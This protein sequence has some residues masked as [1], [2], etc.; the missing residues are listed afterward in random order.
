MSPTRIA[1]LNESETRLAYVDSPRLSAELLM[2]EVLG[3]SRLDLVLERDHLVPVEDVE[4]IKTLVERRALGEPV[5]YIL[6]RKEFYGLEFSVTPD[7]LIPR[8]ETEHL[9]EMVEDLYS[10][11]FQFH[12]ADLGT[13]SGILAVTIAKLFPH[14]SCLAMDKSPD[15]LEVARR[16]AR[17]H[18][19]EDRIVFVDGD[20]TRPLPDG[21]FDLI[22]SNP[23]YVTERE[24]AE[25]SREVSVFEPI[26][27]LVSGADGL[28]HVRAMLK[29]VANGLITE[30]RFLLEIGC[31]QGEAIK[32]ITSRDFPEFRD[33]SVTKDLAG[34]DRVVFLQK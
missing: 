25:A 18:G 13:G 4:R 20:F 7:V 24:L 30:G 9:V 11:N 21:P 19:V 29:H 22:V 17:R 10:K 26:A 14:S 12:F 27:A 28:D 3:C 8:P 1:L 33:V 2:A 6:G 5:A 32:K 15:A 34:H 31:E 23:P 16:N